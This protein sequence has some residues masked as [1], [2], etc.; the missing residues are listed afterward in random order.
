MA[1]FTKVGRRVRVQFMKNRVRY[2]KTLPTKAECIAWAARVAQE[3]VLGAAPKGTTLADLLRRYAREVSP[4][5]RGFKWE[6]NRLEA[7][8]R[9]PLGVIPLA[10]L[11]PQHL[12]DWRDE[13]LEAV[14]AGTVIR[15]F[16][17]LSAVFNRAVK[18]WEWLPFNPLTKVSRPK[19]PPPRTRRITDD[20]ATRIYHACGYSFDSPPI[21]LQAKVGAAFRFALANAMRAGEIVGLKPGD[22]SGKV[23]K[24]HGKTG[25][26][27]VPL[28]PEGLAVL[29][30]ML[31]LKHKHVFGLTSSQ[32]DA[33]FRKA[34][35]RA[36]CDDLH[37][38]D[39]RA[40]SLTRLSRKVDVL[41]LARIS[42]HRDIGLLHRVYYRESAEEIAA[43]L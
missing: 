8:S 19:A 13:R 2:S 17:L 40:E 38:H 20:E 12:A 5:K 30:Q 1:T 21:T 18:E 35:T 24:V 6:R 32:L 9:G 36:M 29:E 28:T 7:V 31:P 26:R 22:I 11:R 43:R 14:E 3:P 37:F 16:I 34:T 39:S 33:L 10:D 4:K 23:A 27:L 41:T 42:G 15:D 25:T